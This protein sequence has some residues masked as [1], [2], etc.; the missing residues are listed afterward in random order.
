MHEIQFTVYFCGMSEETFSKQ[1]MIYKPISSIVKSFTE[2]TLRQLT[3]VNVG[4]LI[5]YLKKDIVIREELGDW[6]FE[7]FTIET[8]YIRHQG[9][10]LGLQKDKPISEVFRDFKVNRLEF[11]YFV[12]GGA[13]IHNETSYR[14]TIHP[15]E[16]IHE[17]MPHVHVSKAGVEIRYSLET[18][19]PIDPLVN[20]HKRDDKKII[21]PFLQQN[22][23]QLRKLWSYYAKGYTT[24]EITEDGQQFYS[25]S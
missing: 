19:L 24:P 7:N 22:H 16:K 21:M 9:Y 3:I 18:L 23:E 8:V 14:F 11:A 25:E 6:G 13:S 1:I 2:T 5:N 15:D 12:V 4:H 20:P 17:H 10:L